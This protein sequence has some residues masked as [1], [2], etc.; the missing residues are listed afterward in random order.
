MSFKSCK[1]S[2]ISE[3]KNHCWCGLG[4]RDLLCGLDKNPLLIFMILPLM[5]CFVKFYINILSQYGV[6]QCHDYLTNLEA[7]VV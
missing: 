7:L 1:F 4:L 2:L 5:Q 6:M 3:N